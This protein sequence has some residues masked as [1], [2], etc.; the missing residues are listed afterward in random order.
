MNLEIKKYFIYFP[1]HDL[2]MG[3]G[4]YLTESN[5]YAKLYD[6][7]IGAVKTYKIECQKQIEIYE[8]HIKNNPPD[9]L[10]HVFGLKALA[11]FAAGA[12]VY[13]LTY[14]L[15]NRAKAQTLQELT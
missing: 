6:T 3:R 13:E 1:S 11:A 8:Y 14:S 7:E 5:A 15:T 10:A 2:Y 9:S 12:E 4:G